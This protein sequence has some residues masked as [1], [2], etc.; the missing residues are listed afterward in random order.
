MREA[1]FQFLCG[2]S[3]EKFNMLFGIVFPHTDAIIYPDPDPF[4]H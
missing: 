4:I 2:L 1:N 3:A